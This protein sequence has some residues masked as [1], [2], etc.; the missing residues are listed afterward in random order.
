MDAHK[1]QLYRDQLIAMRSAIEDL[2]ASRKDSSST[3]E[4]DQTRTGRLSRM[5]ALQGQ[6]MA[7]AGH[8]RSQLELR[9]IE[10][11]LKRIESGDFGY[12]IDCEESISPARLQ[13]NPTVTLCVNCAS[14]REKL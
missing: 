13:A 9:R 14:L 6:A 1:L 4:L 11:A 7:K 10:T 5:D 8:I 12:C 3:V 2:H